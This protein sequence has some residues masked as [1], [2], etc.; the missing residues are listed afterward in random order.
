MTRVFIRDSLN[1]IGEK[2]KLAGWV[3]A[4]RDHGKLIFI[5]LR[6]KTGTIQA[7]FNNKDEKIFKLAE[8]LRQDY[9]I[10]IEGFLRERPQSMV[11]QEIE[12]G[13]VEVSADNL[14]ILNKAETP[15]FDENK[16]GYDINE[17]LRLKYRYLDLR[18]PRLQNNL[19]MRHSV[20]QYIRD[21][22]TK[23][24]FTEIETP[25]LTKSTPEGA[26]DYVVPSRLRQGSFYAIPQSPQQYKQ[27]LMVAGFERYFQIARCFRDEDTRG[28]RQPEFTQLDIEMS[29][30][31]QNDILAL[32]E[33]LFTGLVRKLYPQKKITQSPWPRLSH[34]RAQKEF[35]TDKPDLRKDKKNPDELAFAWTIDFPLF[36]K[37]TEEDFFHGSGSAKF[38]PSHHM[39]TAPH[40]DDIALLD[41]DPL[42]VRGLQHDFVLNG[43]EVGGGSI[44]IH[45]PE[46][47][48]KIFDLIGF[49]A[50]QKNNFQHLLTAFTYGVPPHGGIAPGVDR[51]MM[52]LQNE[53]N[54]REVIA[55]PKTGDGRDPM[56]GAPSEISKKQ[57]KELG[58]KIATSD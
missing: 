37:Q 4:R 47:Q 40:P 2:I 46:V 13:K 52:I 35:G 17:E 32:I 15:F 11:N 27:L 53:P 44:R 36:A 42:K 21:Y 57:L 34:S 48:E 20:I 31:E 39:F 58:I 6:D 5:D 29:F 28:D 38:A 22:L 25:I 51:F 49:T 8:E 10:E 33:D 56:M 26:R 45:Q 24:N 14:K 7:V 12:S 16:E 3:G 9:V 50:E 41:T 18:R 1:K 30:V 23:N 54:I 55:F 19:E 43:Y